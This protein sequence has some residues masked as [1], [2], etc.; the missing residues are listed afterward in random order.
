LPTG[1]ETVI[2]RCIAKT[3]DD[4]YQNTGELLD[5]LHNLEAAATEVDRARGLSSKAFADS[6]FDQPHA[7]TPS[8]VNLDTSLTNTLAT[9]PR[10]TRVLIGVGAVAII[11]LLTLGAL[12]FSTAGNRGASGTEAA[13]DNP[14]LLTLSDDL[15]ARAEPDQNVTAAIRFLANEEVEVIG[16]VIPSGL[17]QARS[18]KAG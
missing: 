11:V 10:H 13:P 3:P 1:I 12:L 2:L 7:V 18:Q 15:F 14:C 4:R 9:T 5:H 8:G 16:K 17:L 6:Q